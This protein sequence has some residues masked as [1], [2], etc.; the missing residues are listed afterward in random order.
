M[1]Y[2]C[3]C[4]DCKRIYLLYEDNYKT[5]YNKINEYEEVVEEKV[6]VWL[7]CA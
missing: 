2:K 4:N 1:K 7:L 5:Y 3:D 6:E